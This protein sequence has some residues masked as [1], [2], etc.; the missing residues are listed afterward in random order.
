MKLLAINAIY[1]KEKGKQVRVEPGATFEADGEEAEYL[2]AQKAVQVISDEKAKKAPAKK[3]APKKDKTPED[4]VVTPAAV[5]GSEGETAAG[6][7]DEDP[8]G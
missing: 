2:I 1:R 6:E 3:A 4:P 5:T 8:L 7:T